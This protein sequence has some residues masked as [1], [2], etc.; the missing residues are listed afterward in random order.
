M[1]L[2]DLGRDTLRSQ[3]FYSTGK[4]LHILAPSVTLDRVRSYRAESEVEKR[5]V[6]DAS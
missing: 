4:R 3:Q 5:R 1:G 2:N 6:H